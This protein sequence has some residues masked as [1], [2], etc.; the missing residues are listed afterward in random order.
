MK[1]GSAQEGLR[2]PVLRERGKEIT[3]KRGGADRHPVAVIVPGAAVAV[4]VVREEKGE[5]PRFQYDAVLSS[6]DVQR[7]ALQPEQLQL[8]VQVRRKTHSFA[9]HH[10]QLLP[11]LPPAFV[12][13]PASC[14]R[15]TVCL[16]FFRRFPGLV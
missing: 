1:P 4:Y 15:H 7:S 2:G 8:R 13:G 11:S 9:A 5:V 3:E 16:P 12:K 6:V 14:S 10:G